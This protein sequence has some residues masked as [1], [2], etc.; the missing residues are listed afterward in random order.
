MDGE[1]SV[2]DEKNKISK[3]KMQNFG[4]LGGMKPRRDF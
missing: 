2:L 4:D 1:R 3:L